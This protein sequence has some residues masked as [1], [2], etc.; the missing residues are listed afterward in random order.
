MR[1]P[2]FIAA[3]AILT[4]CTD[5][6]PLTD[7]ARLDPPRESVDATMDEMPDEFMLTFT[8]HSE[9]ILRHLSISAV[10]TWAG[11]IHGTVTMLVLDRDVQLTV[12]VTELRFN[13]VDWWCVGTDDPTVGPFVIR[14]I[15]DGRAPNLDETLIT[16]QGISCA[17][18][19][20][21]PG[22]VGTPVP[23]GSDFRGMS[24]AK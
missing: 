18:I 6:T 12:P 24:R 16:L 20:L 11:D 23:D 21:Q 1:F 5:G 10:Q 2:M 15:G 9:T 13:G 3:A 8:G 22:R 14:D 19:Y 4:S 17:D 7:A